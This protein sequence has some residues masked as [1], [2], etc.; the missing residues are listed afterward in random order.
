MDS[1]MDFI[2]AVFSWASWINSID[3][4]EQQFRKE[5]KYFCS[6]KL[7]SITASFAASCTQSQCS[8]AEWVGNQISRS[9]E[10]ATTRFTICIHK[11]KVQ[12]RSSNKGRHMDWACILQDH[13]LKIESVYLH[14]VIF[15][16]WF[17][18]RY[19]TQF[20]HHLHLHH[21]HHPLSHRH[22]YHDNHLDPPLKCHLV[23]NQSL[24]LCPIGDV[25][26][27]ESLTRLKITIHYHSFTVSSY[28]TYF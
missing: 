3:R 12:K 28:I 9:G 13:Q 10:H 23:G 6:I 4:I 14:Q 20:L 18:Y 26:R 25:G 21:H 15:Y 11:S 17:C 1:K 16:P 19:H 27:E 22:I 8:H 24:Q 5:E 2:N 7:Y